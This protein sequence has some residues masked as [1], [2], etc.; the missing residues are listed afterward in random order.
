MQQQN[1]QIQEEEEEEISNFK[2]ITIIT[3]F[4]IFYF[5][6]Q[7]IKSP[8]S[9]Q[10]TKLIVRSF[11]VYLIKSILTK[12]LLNE[13]D[14][15]IIGKKNILTIFISVITISLFLFFDESNILI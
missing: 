12:Y 6:I 7:R 11:F 3:L 8:I 10:L 14:K 2:F 5:F 4:T 15:S 9:K 13:K 1:N